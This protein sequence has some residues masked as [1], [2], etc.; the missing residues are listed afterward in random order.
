MIAYRVRIADLNQHLFEIECSIPNPA[1]TEHLSLPSWIPGSYLLREYARHVV[2]ID[3]TSPGQCVT[4]IKRD[5]ST[6]EITGAVNALTVVIRVFALDLSVRGAYLDGQ[7]GY[8]NGTCVFLNVHGREREPI[9][10]TIE[11]PPDMRCTRWRVGTAMSPVET[12]TRGFGRYATQSYDELIDRPVE[13]SDFARVDF[14]AAGIP[15]ALI[16][17]GRHQS[18]LARVAADLRQLCEAHL[19]LFG[20]PAPFEQ[21]RF[22]GLAVEKGF[23]GLE[24]CTSSSLIFDA[25]DLPKPGEAGIPRE[26]QRFLGLCSH[27]YFH[28]WHVKRL[29]PAAFSPYRLNERNYTR[30]LWVFEG[31]TI[32]YQDLMLLRSDLIGREAYLSR[33]AQTLT[34]VYRTPG[35]AKQTLAEASYDAWDKLYKPDPNSPNAT[36]SYYSKGAL[37]ALALDLTLRQATDSATTLDSVLLELWKRYGR[38]DKGLGEADFEKVCEELAGF[39]MQQFFETAVR[40]TADLPL[41]ELLDTF[42]VDLDLRAASGPQDSGGTPPRR[43]VEQPLGLGATYTDSGAG[44]ELATVL[45]DG[46]AEAA[47]LNPGDRLIALGNYHVDSSSLARRLSRFEPGERVPVAFFR[48]GELLHAEMTLALAP[49]DTCNLVAHEQPDPAKH[50]RRLAWLGS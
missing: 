38:E 14:V 5:N 50:A 10:V 20:L 11:S 35:R 44:L 47:G 18:D 4:A 34:R 12:D 30:L 17:A 1:A 23:G 9:E 15:H 37:V 24:H 26:Y 19:S 25:N 39:S 21:Y 31:V 46:P 42:G 33:L 3:A 28:A 8:F 16:V 45:A 32:Y 22:L 43:D 2:S 49:L 36:I 40:G 7:R 29:K 48:R 6:W 13:I 41:A 27:E